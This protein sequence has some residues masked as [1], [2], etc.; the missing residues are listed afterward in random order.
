LLEAKATGPIAY[1][2]VLLAYRR[3]IGLLVGLKGLLVRAYMS[4]VYGVHNEHFK[5]S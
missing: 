4:A 2:M 3:P 1:A 5:N